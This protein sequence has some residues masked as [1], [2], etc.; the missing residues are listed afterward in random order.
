MVNDENLFRD[1]SFLGKM[2]IDLSLSLNPCWFDRGFYS[3]NT[4]TS[5]KGMLENSIGAGAS[6]I[7]CSK[8]EVISLSQLK[9]GFC[10]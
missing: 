9:G 7:D 1:P 8:V 6:T 3:I 4:L 2:I 5:R 10:Q